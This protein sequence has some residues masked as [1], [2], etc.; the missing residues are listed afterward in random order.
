M[1]DDCDEEALLALTDDE[2]EP[3]KKIENTS[4]L[5]FKSQK[6]GISKS[7]NNIIPLKPR[8][9]GMSSSHNL[10]NNTIKD[11]REIINSRR[12]NKA[13]VQPVKSDQN[14][15]THFKKYDSKSRS[16]YWTTTK[17][18]SVRAK[19]FKYQNKRRNNRYHP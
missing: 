8:I 2:M 18:E 10:G 9:S 5:S 12:Q 6:M 16:Y 11:A 13:V 19:N 1:D 3:V 4:A 14:D 17:A 7:H 15:S